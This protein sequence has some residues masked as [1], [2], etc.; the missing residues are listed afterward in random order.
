MHPTNST[1]KFQNSHF[2]FLYDSYLLFQDK[3][4]NYKQN[5]KL[6]KFKNQNKVEESPVECGLQADEFE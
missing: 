5:V 2:L 1:V 4:C 3:Y 6:V